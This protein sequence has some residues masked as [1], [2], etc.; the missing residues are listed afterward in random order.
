MQRSTGGRIAVDAGQSGIRLRWERAGEQLESDVPGI[1]TDQPLMP[2]VAAAVAEF[3][4]GEGLAPE[5]LGL[6]CSGL[7]TP[8]AT[9]LLG[10]VAPYGVRTAVVAHD[11]TTSYLGALGERPGVVIA[12]GT[13]AVTLA[14]GPTCVA[15]VDG[16]GNLLGDAGSAY[17]IGRA[18][19]DAALRGNDGR[20]QL[21]LLT[22][23][24]RALFPDLASAYVELQ[25]DPRRVSRIAA[26]ARVVSELADSDPVSATILDQAAAELSESV[27][28]ALH[29]VSLMGPPPP[30]V[31]A[32][33]KVLSAGHI[34]DRF[35]RYLQMQWPSLQ[36]AP[37]EGTSLDGAARLADLHGPL[38]SLVARATL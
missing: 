26:F 31:C 35:T 7:V 27:L 14:V 34:L 17:W 9:E 37:P 23:R 25:T 32:L 36:L 6:G 28:A 22:D 12:A 19:M 33:G 13:G 18:G 29:R 8:E 30:A 2:Q 15:R 24:L 20:G 38:T 10:L 11:A 21:T 5:F 4:A 3:V 16:W 1:L